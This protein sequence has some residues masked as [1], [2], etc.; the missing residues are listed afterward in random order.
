MPQMSPI[1]WSSILV[2]TSIMVIQIMSNI[3]FDKE[4]KKKKKINNNNN[5]TIKMKW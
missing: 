2:L 5:K 3:E 4:K 1:W